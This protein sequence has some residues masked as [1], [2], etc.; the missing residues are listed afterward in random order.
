MEA[1]PFCGE[2]DVYELALREMQ[3]VRGRRVDNIDD[4]R[5]STRPEV[6]HVLRPDGATLRAAIHVP[7]ED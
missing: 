4:A 2:E 1:R 6:L 3:R 7:A 5:H